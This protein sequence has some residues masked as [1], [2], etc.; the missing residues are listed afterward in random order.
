MR[1]LH[2]HSNFSDGQST[3]EE[4][5]QAALGL[6]LT[7]LGFSDHS[8]TS[9]DES[10][11][12]PKARL[13]EYK[14]AI[15]AL[16][17]RYRDQIRIL[18]GIEQDYYSD[19]PAVGYDYVIGSVHAVK[20]GAAYLNVDESAQVQKAAVEEYFGGDYYAFAELYFETVADV[21]RKTNADIIGHFDLVSKFCLF[22]ESH[23]RYIAAWKQAV[24]RLLPSGKPFEIN[25]G[26]IS[27]G[28]RS[29]PY[30]NPQMIA[31]IREKGG[32]FVL[33]SDSHRADTLCYCFEKY[34]NWV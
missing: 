5:V 10:C 19:E 33:S 15:D 17:E 21:V 34:E 6:G 8:Y 32:R 1:D 11:C 3:P 12:I 24:D 20:V 29:I 7:E 28:Y 14:Q 13:P 23:P 25:T 2:V 27:R 26:A 30:P 4:I 22:D 9:Y 18:C 31:Y 16:K